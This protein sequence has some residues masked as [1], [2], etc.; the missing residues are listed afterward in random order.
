MATE[1]L[2]FDI[3]ARD[4]ASPSFKN[5]GRAA[6][7]ASGNLGK[8]SDRLNEIAHQ[9]AAARVKLDGD[10]EAEQQLD[11]LGRSILR[12]SGRK[13]DPEVDLQGYLRT[14]E[15]I[16][17]LELA[18]DR[19]NNKRVTVHVG[20]ARGFLNF[21]TGGAEEGGGG[22]GGLLGPA[23]I[24]A[25]IGGGAIAAGLVPSVVGLGI[26]GIAGAGA[27]GGGLAGA[28]KGKT[29]LAADKANISHLTTGLKA[30][31]G[32]QRQQISAELKAA[33]KQYAKDQAFFAPFTQLQKSL[34]GLMRDVLA[35]LRPVMAPLAKIF[36][37]FGKG[38]QGLGPQFTALFKASLPFIRQFLVFMLQAGKILLPAFTQ[39]MT[40]M[41]K[42]GALQQ[43]TQALV[44]L[45]Q[46]LAQFIV[47]LGPGM[48]ASAEIFARLATFIGRTLG[49]L[50]KLF[51]FF[52]KI[53]TFDV[54]GAAS[55]GVRAVIASFNWWRDHVAAIL[56]QV[57]GWFRALPG[58]IIGALTGLGHTLYSFA[59]AALNQMWSG[60]KA[61]G[62]AIISWVGNF[63]K[64]IWSKVK[65]FFGIASPS[66][67]FYDIGRNLMLGLFHGIKD[68]A[69]HAVNALGAVGDTG[70]RSGSARIAQAYARSIMGRWGFGPG[71][72]GALQALWNRESGWNAYAV[73]P[74]SGAAGIPQALGHGH[75]FNLG[76]YK[77][78]IVWGL[79]YI[80]GRYGSP[81]GAWAHEMQFGWY[82]KGGWLPPG[83][84]LA[85][86]KTG[87]PEPVGP[88]AQ[89]GPMVVIENLHV[90]E[91][92]DIDLIAR[93]L[94]FQL[95][96]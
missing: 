63:A 21:L 93:R 94:S 12:L 71:Q 51:T 40:E 49:F 44:V 18:L 5:M 39:A 68:H 28:A 1:R 76:D 16:T 20:V 92:A 9:T 47:N 83:L 88:A 17:R 54:P 57:V 3:L 43:M 84:S 46:G 69:H 62:G 53:L 45:T 80:L 58:R 81:A 74:S 91:A 34:G 55:K 78:Q 66:S 86:N 24:G 85:L 38:L 42:S 19:L 30:A 48:K 6:S 75:V 23:G 36:G 14:R 79:N 26:G 89:G 8:L 50:G 33:N 13:V 52:A 70:A 61:I 72:F 77:A 10:K 31:I 35:P 27:V 59:H 32:Q 87:R 15:Q 82:D 25:L 37:E 7:D 2:S 73:N 65:S 41:V 90:R 67:V 11:R 95:G 56:G 64:S 29:T 4:L 96:Q 60:F 22:G